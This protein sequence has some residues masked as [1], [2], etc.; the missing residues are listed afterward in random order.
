MRKVS[1]ILS[2]IMILSF[3]V[4]VFGADG[5]SHDGE[6]HTPDY[7]EHTVRKAFKRGDWNG[8]KRLLDEGLE[9]YPDVSGL[10]ELAGSYYLHRQAFDDARYHLVLAVR[11]NDGNVQAKQMLVDVEEKTK[12]YSSAICYVNE[13]LQVNPYWKGLWRRKI[14][15]FRKQ[16]NDVEADRLLRRLCQIYPNDETLKRDLAG[17]LEEQYLYNRRHGTK[18]ATIASLRQLIE[19]YPKS[20]EYYMQLSNLLLQ[21]GHRSEAID[22]ADRGVQNIPGSAALVMKKAGILAEENRYSEAMSF[23]KECMKR[24]HSGRLSSF[25]NSLQLDAA[26]MEANQDPY[27]L[28]GKVYEK[29]K[30]E[31]SLNYLLSTAMSRGYYEDALYYIG[32]AR[33]RKGDTPDLLYKSYI[34]NKRMGNERAANGL[35]TRLYERTPNNEEIADALSRLRLEQASRLMEDGAYADALG[36]LKFVAEHASDR[37]T[38]ESAYSRIYTCNMGLRRYDAAEEALQTMHRNFPSRSDY[39]D[40]RA[41][42]LV[43]RGRIAEALRFIKDEVAKTDDEFMRYH[44]IST[45]EYIAT[46]YIKDLIANGATKKAFEESEALLKLYPASERGLQYAINSAAK[47]GYWSEFSRLVLQGRQNYPDDRFYLVKQA[48][49]LHREGYYAD[50]VDILRS[51]LDDYAGDTLLVQ[52]FSTNSADWATQLIKVRQPDSA[53]AVVDSALIFDRENRTLLYTKGLA[54]EAKHEYD[55]AYIYQKYYRPS[56]A[57]YAEFYRHLGSLQAHSH[58][59]TL[60]F[61]YLQGR[62]GELDAITAVATAEYSRKLNAKNDM[63][64]RVNYAGREGAVAG[65]D[66]EEQASG[67]TGIQLQGQWTRRF[68]DKW[69]GTA[70]AAWANKYF[71]QLYLSAQLQ[72]NLKNDW[73][74]EAHANYRRIHSYQKAW[75]WNPDYYNA[76]LGY[77]AQGIWEFDHWDHSYSSLLSVGVGASKT[78]GDFWVNS[79][80]DT[81]MLKSRLY[82]NLS[83]QGKYYPLNDSKTC[84]QVL[85]SVGSAPE[86]TMI[87]FAMPGTFNH[88]NTMVGF[89]GQYRL[90][91]NVTVGVL[92]TW[93]T[94]YTQTQKRRTLD[95]EGG[96]YD[97]STINYKNLFNIDAQ[98][99]ITF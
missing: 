4:V 94:Y 96:Y 61:E 64:I 49:I 32:Q 26:R 38:C 31:E 15:L 23:V 91:K 17:R 47:L 72:R 2:V 39:V 27:V 83:A 48:S 87:D 84:F 59:N 16:G 28:Y 13:L 11:D 25:Y 53:I 50:A 63:A 43:H 77:D 52:A 10:N 95:I 41:D 5:F 35:L 30:S 34:V 6:I 81:Y 86:V 60:Y 85:G 66:P 8:G 62:F 37:E 57:E 20:E 88:L 98:L 76:E 7:Y 54:F 18:T 89:G 69:E 36:M 71:P 45:Y 68:S 29:S 56:F 14:A 73:E 90:L 22:I 33:K 93:Y 46:P 40:K 75:R 9:H 78:L 65:A 1:I 82:F 51:S 42:L 74:V 58:R 19:Q 79:K 99:S 3:G 44:Y 12:N 80:F 92:G 21:Q 67:G 55:S 70:A 24:N 97:Y